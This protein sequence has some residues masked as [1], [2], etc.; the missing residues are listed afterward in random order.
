M[1]LKVKFGKNSLRTELPRTT[2]N[3]FRKENTFK[4]LFYAIQVYATVLCNI[5]FQY[6]AHILM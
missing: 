6:V 4:K 2:T 5:Y 1:K 3:T